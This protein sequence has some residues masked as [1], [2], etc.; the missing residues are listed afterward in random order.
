MADAIS[1]LKEAIAP[2]QPISSVHTDC[3]EGGDGGAVRC[4]LTEGA[5]KEER[6]WVDGH[7]ARAH[8]LLAEVLCLRARADAGERCAE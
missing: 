4:L 7:R 2:T 5:D 1:E 6:Q 8:F 3:A